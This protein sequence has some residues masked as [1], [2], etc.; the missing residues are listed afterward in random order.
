MGCRVRACTHPSG[1]HGDL[2][3]QAL[4][5]VRRLVVARLPGHVALQHLLLDGGQLGLGALQRVL[6][7]VQQLLFNSRVIGTV[8]DKKTQQQQHRR[9]GDV[10]VWRCRHGPAARPCPPPGLRR[11]CAGSPLPASD[12]SARRPRSLVPPRGRA[13]PGRLLRG[14]DARLPGP[15]PARA[16]ASWPCSAP[17]GRP[18]AGAAQWR[19]MF[20]RNI[21][22]ETKSKEGSGHTWL[23]SSAISGCSFFRLSISSR[24][25][26]ICRFNASMVW[27]ARSTWPSFCSNAARTSNISLRD[28]SR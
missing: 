22:Q 19:Q 13:A 23:E 5:H 21:R 8:S 3:V 1:E 11:A 28:S 10:S 7:H 9:Y 25:R 14:A 27:S 20:G 17:L 16:C 6:R 24:P 15:C 18:P 12:A 26:L 2:G 4:R